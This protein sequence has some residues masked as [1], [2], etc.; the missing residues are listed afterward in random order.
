MTLTGNYM[1]TRAAALKAADGI[2]TGAKASARSMTADER[3][4]VE[5]HLKTVDTIDAE[6][7]DDMDR[8]H[9][10]AELTPE[11][12]A[13]RPAV[14]IFTVAQ[15]EGI[16][17]AV[18]SRSMFRAEVDIKA[19]LTTA[20]LPTSGVGV[21]GGLFPQAY[22]LA[23]LFTQ[24]Q[25]DGPSVRYYQF[26]AATAAVV[27]QGA[28]KPDAGLTITAKD[29]VIEKIA[30]TTRFS[31]EFADDA[32]FLMSHV[33]NELI[34]AVIVKE[35]SEILATFAGTSGIMTATGTKVTALDVYADAIAVAEAVNG[36]LPS[37][38]ITNP[39]D[40]AAVRKAKSSTGGSYFLDPLSPTPAS[41]HGVKLISSAVVAS[42]TAWLASAAGVVI[43]RR[44]GI[45]V[46]IGYNAD[47]FGTNQRTLRVEER[48]IAA[49]VRPSML[50]KITLT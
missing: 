43:Y 20:S 17:S 50:T 12:K 25:A 41:V 1:A 28:T 32:P 13:G 5:A 44:G 45:V 36:V 27:A 23:N 19:A 39:A 37:A 34:S 7:K 49:A 21:V 16:V 10:L 47:D 26:D 6:V 24:T 29:A 14:P 31:D 38:L 4:I 11:A 3:S 15:A 33:Q 9:R 8:L 42:G 40:L 2:V 35:N 18:K 30:T 48:F 46:D 22:P